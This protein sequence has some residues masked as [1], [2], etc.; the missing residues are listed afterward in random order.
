MDTLS[1]LVK[2]FSRAKHKGYEGSDKLSHSDK[3][4]GR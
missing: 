3:H 2:T 1:H 4:F